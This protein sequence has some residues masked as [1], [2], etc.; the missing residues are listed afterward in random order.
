MDNDAVEKLPDISVAD[1][2]G[3][4]SF[5]SKEEALISKI[6]QL[7]P[8]E[9]RLKLPFAYAMENGVVLISNELR[10]ILCYRGDISLDVIA[11]VKRYSQCDFSMKKLD[12]DVFDNLITERYQQ[13]SMEAHR[14]AK[15]MSDN[16]EDLSLSDDSDKDLLDSNSENSPMV[17]FVNALLAQAVSEEVS[18]I[19]IEPFETKVVIRFRVDGILREHIS[20]ERKFSDYLIARIKIMA[21]LNISEKRIPQDGRITLTIGGKQVDVRVS[22]I[23]TSYSERIV[24]R[25]LDKNNIRLELAQL[26]MSEANCKKFYELIHMPH[27]IILVTGPTG[28]GKSTTLYAAISEINTKDINIM[29]VEDPVEYELEGIGQ[30]PVNPKVDMTF[31][32]ALRSLLRQDPDVVMIGE[33]RDQETAEIAVQASLTGHLVLSTLHTNTAV[34]AITRL[35]DMG[36]ES[37]LLSTSLLGVLA[38]RLVRRLCPHCKQKV[39]ATPHERAFLGIEEGAMLY[40]PVGCPECND[41]GYKGRCGIYELIEVTDKVRQAIHDEVGEIEIEKIVRQNSESIG[42]DGIN[43]ILSGMTTITEVMRVANGD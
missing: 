31:A 37:Y 11:E 7:R 2:E 13:D 14:L 43:K 34:G 17:R 9:E 1:V 25:L 3:T 41:T 42:Q 22:T 8:H 28:S 26:G 21:K 36:I 15:N 40:K 19:H 24:M 5:Y 38:Q 35:N 23:P 30:T 16:I 33:I 10:N 29:T 6:T 4:K 32:R 27:G 39:L 18:D 12:N 20:L